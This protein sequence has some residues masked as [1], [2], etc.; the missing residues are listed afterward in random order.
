MAKTIVNNNIKLKSGG[1]ILN[2]ATDG[3]SVDT[4]TTDGKIV[5]VG[6]G[7]KL[8]AVDGSNLTEINT[9]FVVGTG[10]PS[11][12]FFW[13]YQLPHTANGYWLS[14]NYSSPSYYFSYAN[15][16]NVENTNNGTR[17]QAKITN[18]VGETMSFQTKK[19]IIEFD[20]KF[21]SGTNCNKYIG[22]IDNGQLP[23]VYNSA[24]RVSVAFVTDNS[25]KLYAKTSTGGG[26]VNHTEEEITGITLT[27]IN[28]YRIEF[29]PGVNAKFY[30][31]GELKKTITTTLP[32]SA[33]SPFISISNVYIGSPLNGQPQYISIVNV[34]VEK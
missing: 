7:N 26:G 6:T 22:L 12:K 32:S 29:N 1:G 3:L 11:G 23:E 8:P 30:I 13:T 16:G 18:Q 5:Q 21:A 31:N 28:T 2:N 20:L 14:V 24:D 17:Y 25:N 10:R 9:D 19:M 15:L 33:L 27:N 4:G 34:S